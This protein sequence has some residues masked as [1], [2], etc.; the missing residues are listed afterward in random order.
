MHTLPDAWLAI[1][2]ALLPIFQ[3]EGL[4]GE[5]EAADPLPTKL[6]RG[7]DEHLTFLT[8]VYTISGGRKPEQLSTAARK[9]WDEDPGL[10]DPRGLAFAK[11]RDLEPRLKSQGL[12]R[13][14]KSEATVWQRIGK[15]LFMRAGGSVLRLLA[16]NAHDAQRLLAM[17]EQSKTT[18]P[19]LSGPQ[20]APRWIY[21][22]A[23]FGERSIANLDTLAATGFACLCAGIGP[24][25]L[26]GG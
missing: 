10:F 23:R 2:E 3:E 14:T 4:W 21:G 20:T 12:T 6:T 18:F 1:Q 7:S 13:K 11:P 17:L 8:L 9:T 16:D 19:V 26:Y 5:G 22:L 15:A 25:G 24:I